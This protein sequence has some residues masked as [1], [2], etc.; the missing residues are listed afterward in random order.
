MK[1]NNEDELILSGIQSKHKGSFLEYIKGGV[2]LNMSIA[3]D[4][5]LSN[6]K[7]DDP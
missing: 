3:V 5:T 7:W 6:K 2:D 4:Y 1:A